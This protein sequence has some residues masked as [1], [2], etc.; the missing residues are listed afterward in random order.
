MTSF[1][2]VIYLGVSAMTK[3]T[4]RLSTALKTQQ[5][6][7]LAESREIQKRQRKEMRELFAR[8]LRELEEEQD[9]LLAWQVLRQA[10]ADGL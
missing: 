3:P 4:V 9:S 5:S 1:L 6:K 8:Q 10:V 2:W 7:C